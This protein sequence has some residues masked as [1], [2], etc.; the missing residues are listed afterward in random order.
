MLVHP[1]FLFRANVTAAEH[2]WVVSPQPGVDWVRLGGRGAE[3]A[4][5]TS[6]V[7]HAPASVFAVHGH[8]TGLAT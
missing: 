5:A 1:D 8:E 7:R 3:Q 6:T 4:R 2:R